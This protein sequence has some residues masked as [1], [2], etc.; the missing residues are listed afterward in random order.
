VLL[1]ALLMISNIRYRTF[2][3][4]SGN[5]FAAPAIVVLALA[6]LVAAWQTSFSLMMVIV[7]TGL[8]AL[9]PAEELVRFVLRRLHRRDENEEEETA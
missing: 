1:L 4:L 8:I 7:C 5:R 6:I 3:Q 9:G 2:K